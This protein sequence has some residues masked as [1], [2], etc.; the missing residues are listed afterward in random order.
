MDEYSKKILISLPVNPSR[1]EGKHG[2]MTKRNPQGRNA[3]IHDMTTI[4]LHDILKKIIF[5][6]TY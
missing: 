6:C 3:Q 2:S 4:N 5:T 1:D